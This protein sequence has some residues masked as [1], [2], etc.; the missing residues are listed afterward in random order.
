MFQYIK[1]KMFNQNLTFRQSFSILNFKTQKICR[2]CE[3]CIKFRILYKFLN[4]HQNL[5]ILL[6]KTF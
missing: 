6:D 4:V 5:C 1:L 3:K 2:R